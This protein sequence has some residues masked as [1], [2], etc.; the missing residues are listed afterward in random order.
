MR[1]R[2]G[3]A[4]ALLAVV[5]LVA[6]PS[7]ADAQTAAIGP[8][9][10]TPSWDQTL[11]CSSTSACPRFIVLSN[12]ANAAVLDRETGLVWERAPSATQFLYATFIETSGPEHCNEDVR[13]GNRLGWRLPSIQELAS[14]MDLTVSNAPALPPGSPFTLPPSGV[15]SYMSSTT[16]SSNTNLFWGVEFAPVPQVFDSLNK[17]QDR[18]FVWCVRG[19]QVA[20]VQ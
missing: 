18:A 3:S 2:F 12:F 16:R 5:F 8:Y 6:S 17:T 19:G 14:L 4:C 10:A 20:D 1:H 11:A 7:A 15:L 13:L 9:Y